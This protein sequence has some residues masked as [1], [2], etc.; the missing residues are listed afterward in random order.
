MSRTP[1]SIIPGLVYQ[2]ISRFVDREWFITHER[3]R[4]HYVELL[5]RAIEKSD[6]R[7]IGYSVM[8]NH[9][10]ISAV[11]G[12][13]SLASWSALVAQRLSEREVHVTHV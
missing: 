11:A 3:E 1:R 12:Q 4:T 5:G 13:Q 10:H 8:S 9:Q 2:L 6:W 7:C